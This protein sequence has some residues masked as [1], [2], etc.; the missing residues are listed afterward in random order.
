MNI[1]ELYSQALQAASA[2]ADLILV[3]PQTYTGFTEDDGI[4][5]PATPGFI[6]QIVGDEVISLQ[7]DITDHYV[8]EN[9]AKQDHIALKPKKFTVSGYQGELTNIIP[10]ILRPAQEAVDRLGVLSAYIPQITV[11]AQRAL[12][13]AQQTYALSQKISKAA[14]VYAGVTVQTE[15]EKAYAKLERLWNNRSL[16]WVATPFGQFS[17]MVIESLNATQSEKS[18]SISDFT[19]TFKQVRFTAT[20][21]VAANRI[22]GSSTSTVKGKI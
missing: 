3:S 22:Q 2:A 15:Q 13:I 16:F 5:T 18:K 11:T 9:T 14:Q 7:S 17:D 8:E 6:F 1:G 4:N 21:V 12:S 19:I 10:E 20:Q